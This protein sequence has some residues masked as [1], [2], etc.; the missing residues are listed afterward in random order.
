MN[1]KVLGLL[2]ERRT[3]RKYTDEEISEEQ[4]VAL[5]E[6]AFYAPS[7]LNRKPWHFLVIRDKGVQEKLGAI[8][9]VRPYVQEAS[10]VIALLG[11]P[12]LS[13]AWEL[14]LAAASENILVAATA[15]G[16]GSAWVGN[17]HGAAWDSRAEQIRELFAIPE[18]IGILGFVT[19][20]YPAET[21]EPHA[22]VQSWDVARVHLDRFSNLRSEWAGIRNR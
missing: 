14:D 11:D 20:G 13:T 8:L 16:L 10:A 21:R 5:L 9:S 1:S 12:Q 7:H 15:M 3:I 17:P 19:I 2:R 6:A 18:Y 4:I 22:K